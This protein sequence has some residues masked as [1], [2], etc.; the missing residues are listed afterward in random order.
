MSNV[1][2]LKSAELIALNTKE[3]REEGLRR[4]NA[5]KKL[6]SKA[7]SAKVRAA[8]ALAVWLGLDAKGIDYVRKD[9]T[10][11][12][13]AKETPKVVAKPSK[14]APAKA[15]APKAKASKK[16]TT[17]QRLDKLESDVAEMK[18]LL[19]AIAK[20]LAAK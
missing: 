7:N 20:Q 11:L 1:K 15:P 8:K 13:F 16:P 14:K 12:S 18:S 2:S 19:E 6:G 4:Y 3:A 17:T 9:G 5:T 10:V